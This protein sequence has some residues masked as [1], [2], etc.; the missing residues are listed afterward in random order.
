[1]RA[2]VIVG[3][4]DELAKL[5]SRLVGDSSQ[6]PHVFLIAGEAGIGKSALVRLFRQRAESAGA[7][8][9]IGECTSVEVG[10][11]FGPL[12]E[13]LTRA[14]RA[15][16]TRAVVEQAL[17]DPDLPLPGL[18][19]GRE[20]RA[21][22]TTDPSERYRAHAAV[23]GVLLQMSR[24][25]PLVIVIEDAHWAD[26]ATLDLL[27]YAVRHLGAA[28]LLL[29]VTYRSD[30]LHRLHP[31]V[32]VL[33]ELR[34][35]GVV[36]ELRLPP[37][38][39]AETA[40]MIQ[41]RLGLK[42]PPDAQI[43]DAIFERCEG[44][45]Y[46]TDEV[47][48]TVKV[49]SAGFG[50]MMSDRP[51]GHGAIPASIRDALWT[52]L[53]VLDPPTRN[54]MQLAA[55]IGHRFDFDL[56]QR[57]SGAADDALLAALR[58][59]VDAHV[60]EEAA[61]A[62]GRSGYVF[63]HALMHEA[64]LGELL[65]RHRRS[66]H[67][68]VGLALESMYAD[69][70]PAV[71][72][73]LAFQ[74][75]AAED[76]PRACRYHDLA[77]R[78]AES[79]FAFRSASRHLQRAIAR[80]PD[81]DRVLGDLE[82]RLASAARYGGNPALAVQACESALEH[83][84]RSGDERRRGSIYAIL[85]DAQW[86]LGN[87]TGADAAIG[88]AIALLE[89]LGDT[90]ELALAYAISGARRSIAGDSA[91]ALDVGGKAIALARRLDVPD[92]LGIGLMTVGEA[93]AAFGDRGGL[94][95]IREAV[96][97]GL[98]HGLAEVT[99]AAYGNLVIA[100]RALGA[101]PAE[102]RRV[103]EESAV[104]ARRTGHYRDRF[105]SHDVDYLIADGKWDA[106]LR[107][108][109]EI[110]D[111]IWREATLLQVAVI[112]TLRIGPDALSSAAPHRDRLLAAKDP[113][114]VARAASFSAAALLVH[115]VRSA[116]EFAEDLVASPNS[117]ALTWGAVTRI[118]AIAAACE[119]GD[120]DAKH[121]WIERTLA[122]PRPVEARMGTAARAF[123]QAAATDN[124]EQAIRYLDTAVL[125]LEG[126]IHPLAEVIVRLRR[127]ELHSATPGRADHGSA[128]DDLAVVRNFAER[129]GA[130]WFLQD[131]RRW[132]DEHGLRESAARP[133]A[134]TTVLTRR[135]REIARLVARGLTDREIATHLVIAQRTA[136]GHVA[137]ILEKLGFHTRSEI[138]A[139]STK[140]QLAAQSTSASEKRVPT[141]T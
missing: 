54:I 91:Q 52:R 33:D 122:D 75:D 136:E 23:L 98:R 132:A 18:M 79:A 58:A 24:I 86:Y 87:R 50:V 9:F 64:V 93:R 129:A 117:S 99:L 41:Q 60:V 21:P 4:E 81:D 63:R 7:Q 72:E 57:V 70:L 139:W 74:F 118:S 42:Q 127:A 51:G 2:P 73:E 83:A 133:D 121:T 55:I 108:A 68:V 37:L 56:L 125:L 25:R 94:D 53:A 84:V 107:E 61:D 113:Q 38:G 80:A 27:P 123:A 45:P 47:L 97:V 44:N 11:P 32:P 6:L 85:A 14:Q 31:F 20:R 100:L 30:E 130:T 131:L 92:A 112:H 116:L 71:T 59:M 46:F 82:H 29:L 95:Q 110:G 77:A 140:D 114:W 141:D 103:H 40:A 88:E 26:E 35:V 120:V 102:P 15:P 137:H 135:E 104:I 119:L 106:A 43:R 16:Q 1:M 67:R 34:R 78:L 28:R 48:R 3:R 65:E 36:E 115:D 138:A 62:A 124:V 12:I 105:F 39:R 69:D 128:R 89:P 19:P 13:V 66:L 134:T 76:A 8:V 90:P 111:T 10:R 49:D 101:S 96:D 17:A 126:E 22:K 109:T 5:G